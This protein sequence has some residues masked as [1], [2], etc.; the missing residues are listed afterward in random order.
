MSLTMHVEQRVIVMQI[1]A[2]TGHK[3]MKNVRGT[4]PASTLRQH[5]SSNS[6][7][8]PNQDPQK[9]SFQIMQS[10]CRHATDT[11]AVT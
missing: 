7:P 9:L 5:R 10:T 2:P 4:Q 8:K 3:Q 11:V 6:N 1:Y